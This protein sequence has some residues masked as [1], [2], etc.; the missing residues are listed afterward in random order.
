MTSDPV[1]Q[2]PTL[3]SRWIAESI[4]VVASAVTGKFHCLPALA[5]LLPQM[6]TVSLSVAQTASLDG[7][8]T[9]HTH[10]TA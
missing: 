6:V 5:M 10:L 2:M 9:L 8:N 4:G 3:R 7:V 1:I